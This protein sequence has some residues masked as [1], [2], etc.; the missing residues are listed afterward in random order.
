MS[1][2]EDGQPGKPSRLV[3]N[4]ASH[5]SQA[6]IEQCISTGERLS[7]RETHRRDDADELVGNQHRGRQHG[8]GLVALG[9]MPFRLSRAKGGRSDL[10]F[11]GL[12]SK[13]GDSRTDRNT[14]ANQRS[15][16]D[17]VTNR[18]GENEIIVFL[19]QDEQGAFLSPDKLGTQFDDQTQHGGFLTAGRDS[20][21]GIHYCI[22]FCHCSSPFCWQQ[23]V[24]DQRWLEYDRH[25]KKSR[26]STRKLDRQLRACSHSGRRVEGGYCPWKYNL[27]P[28]LELHVST[29]KRSL[30]DRHDNLTQAVIDLATEHPE[31]FYR[32][33]FPQPQPHRRCAKSLPFCFMIRLTGRCNLACAYC[34][35]TANDAP[36]SSLDLPT[37]GQIANYILSV[38]GDKPLIS[39]LG[40]EPL[41]NWPVGRFL[42]ETIRREAR[43]RGKDPYFNI[44]T[45]GTLINDRLARELVSDDI[46]VQISID[47]LQKGHD[48]HRRYPDGTGSYQAAVRGLQSLRAI[49]PTAK[50]DAQVVL[51]P[52]NTNLR[53]IA[54]E[55]KSLGFRRIYFLYLSADN[56]CSRA[57]WSRAA[58]HELIRQRARFYPYFL[59]SAIQGHAEVDMKFAA[60]IAEQPAGPVGLCGCGWREVYIDTRGDIYPCPKLYGRTDV[61]LLGNCATTDPTA[62]L[63]VRKRS[64]HADEECAECWAFD[65]CQGGCA[66][67]CQKCTL[68]PAARREPTERL[69]CDLLRA[70]FAR[71][72]ITYHL[73]RRF[74]PQSL[75]SLQSLFGNGAT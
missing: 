52:G 66:F 57:A 19:I 23:R 8:L 70:Q 28:R 46:T 2:L 63:S 7:R 59:Q 39:F 10:D 60:L 44:T 22:V 74:H 42:I 29:R 54:K 56:G 40:G 38:P 68:L 50:V 17:G 61:Q 48:H 31:E 1:T 41:A 16:R 67:Q 47:G 30:L 55:L 62:P 35:D 75:S 32:Q 14:L 20:E 5:C 64:R 37:A 58:V 73:L 53:R 15:F 49:S 45:N 51:T 18:H 33:A 65:W 4:H 9:R 11:A 43:V 26:L 36:Q 34:F 25:G 24:A 72:A 69:W 21:I 71:A 3:H 13:A 6:T 27:K 12:C